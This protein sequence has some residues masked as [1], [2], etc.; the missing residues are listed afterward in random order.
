MATII[1]NLYNKL[2]L[3]LSAIINFFA[4]FA[5]CAGN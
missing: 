5:I 2:S 1:Y 4:S 3:S